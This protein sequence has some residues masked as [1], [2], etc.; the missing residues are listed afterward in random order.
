MS[1]KRSQLPEQPI[2]MLSRLRGHD[3]IIYAVG[4]V[5]VTNLK[6]PGTDFALG[7]GRVWLG[8]TSDTGGSTALSITPGEQSLC[9]ELQKPTSI[10]ENADAEAS[11]LIDRWLSQGENRLASVEMMGSDILLTLAD[12]RFVAFCGNA[13]TVGVMAGP[14]VR[15]YNLIAGVVR[16]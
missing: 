11:D 9:V 16:L 13:D 4:D 2:E 6:A 3:V 15:A 5:R 7:V 1:E 12:E 8:C 14:S 10:P